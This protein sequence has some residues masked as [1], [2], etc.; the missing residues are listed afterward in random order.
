MFFRSLLFNPNIYIGHL[1][2]VMIQFCASTTH[3]IAVMT[4]TSF[5]LGMCL[6][7]NAMVVDMEDQINAIEPILSQKKDHR[8]QISLIFIREIR[9]H[10]EIIE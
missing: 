7:I 9:F 2:D 3:L 8:I 10:C 4:A 1:C 5:Y 6:Y